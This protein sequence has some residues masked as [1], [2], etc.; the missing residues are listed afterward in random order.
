MNITVSGILSYPTLHRASTLENYRNNPPKFRCTVLLKKGS[1]DLQ[2]VASKINQLKREEWGDNTPSNFELKCLLDL[3]EDPVTHNYVALKALNGED[4]K[5]RVIDHNGEEVIMS[6]Q[7][8]AGLQCMM[9]VSLYVYTR[10]GNGI[11]AGINGV[12]I[13]DAMGE[14]G[15]LG[16]D[17]LTDEQM[18]GN[19]LVNEPPLRKKESK[20]F[21]E[22]IM[23]KQAKEFGWHKRSDVTGEWD[24]DELLIDNGYM[25]VSTQP[26]W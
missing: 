20:A 14:L 17:R 18:F 7:C 6:S 11:S 25:I 10:S 16:R 24:N 4:D 2:K 9:S 13:M 21:R 12:K 23:T 8:V 3:S 22:F 15:I 19:Q 5:P 1:A 26:D